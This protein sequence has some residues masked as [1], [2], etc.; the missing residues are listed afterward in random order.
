[1]KDFY[2][3]LGLHKGA[4]EEEIKKAYRKMAHEYHPDKKGGDEK[5]FKEVNEAYQVLSN[6]EKRANYDRFGTA[7]FPGG[8][9]PAY[10]WG[11][12]PFHGNE[13]FGSAQGESFGFGFPGDAGDIGD[14]FDAFFEG[15]GVKPRRKSYSRGADL[16]ISEVI[17]LEDALHGV[18]KKIQFKTF[19]KCETCGGEGAELSAGT[20]ICEKCGGQGEVKES[21]KTF[22][23]SFSQVKTCGQCYATGKIPN[24]ICRSCGGVGRVK[25][26]KEVTINILPGVSSGQLI[27]VQGAGESGERGASQG[28]LY[29]RIVIKPHHLFKREGQNLLLRHDIDLVQAL[30]KDEI[31]ITGLRGNKIKVSLTPGFNF[32]ESVKIAGEG[33]PRFGGHDSFGS[34]EGKRGDLFLSF[35]VLKPSKMDPKL[36]KLLDEMR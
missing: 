5:R 2:K 10:G 30:L 21:R 11:G 15:L 16:E 33:M 3:I 24:K 32:A 20:K 25:G 8:G 26:E 28:D 12:F 27:Q 4:T 17:T 7:D 31:L 14:I 23:G 19:I 18:T 1:M 6:K 9:G 13:P 34:T 22:F 29:V 36:K 35:N